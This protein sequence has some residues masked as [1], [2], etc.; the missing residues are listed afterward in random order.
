M[1]EKQD[2]AQQLIVVLLERDD[3]LSR[4]LVDVIRAMDDE[5]REAFNA[6]IAREFLAEFARRARNN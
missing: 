4:L 1:T 5:A 2:L 3:P 6:V